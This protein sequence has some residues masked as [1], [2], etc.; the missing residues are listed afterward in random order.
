[1]VNKKVIVTFYNTI[2]FF[3]ISYA[4]FE[5]EKKLMDNCEFLS[6]FSHFL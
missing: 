1:M 6:Q 5:N 3:F 2:N 4:Y